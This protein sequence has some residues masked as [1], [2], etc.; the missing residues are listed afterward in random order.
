MV[1]THKS[2][3]DNNNNKNKTNGNNNNNNNNNSTISSTIS[4]SSRRRRRFRRQNTVRASLH[5]TPKMYRRR[6]LCP[7][8][9]ILL[10]DEEAGK[11]RMKAGEETNTEAIV[12]VHV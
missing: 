7:P 3:T 12:G 8:F 9:P 6:P 1:T 5:S 2:T 11:R 10:A 4:S